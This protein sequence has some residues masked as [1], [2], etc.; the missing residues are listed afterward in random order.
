[1]AEVK[2]ENSWFPLQ[3][4]PFTNKV[5][6]LPSSPKAQDSTFLLLGIAL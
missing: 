3:T 5:L 4:I 1:M 2:D 6:T